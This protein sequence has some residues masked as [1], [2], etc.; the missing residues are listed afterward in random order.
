VAVKRAAHASV[1]RVSGC[2]RRRSA[3]PQRAGVRLA[4]LRAD[5]HQ[6]RHARQLQLGDAHRDDLYAAGVGVCLRSE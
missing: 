3:A 6:L 1:T 2:R 4:Q 5:G